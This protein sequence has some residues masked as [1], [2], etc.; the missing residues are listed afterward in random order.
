MIK[1]SSISFIIKTIFLFIFYSFVQRSLK[2]LILYCI[3][4][5]TRMINSKKLPW[6]KF[7][8]LSEKRNYSLTA[9]KNHGR[10]SKAK[11]NKSFQA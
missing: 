6:S 9:T 4:L 10:F 5:L 2:M 3:L 1:K 11:Q 7:K 8:S